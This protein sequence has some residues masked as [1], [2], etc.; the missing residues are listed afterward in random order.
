MQERATI[1]CAY[2]WQ[3]KAMERVLRR[4]ARQGSAWIREEEILNTVKGPPDARV[5][6]ATELRGTVMRSLCGALSSSPS[7]RKK[8]LRV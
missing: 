4:V 6:L 1:I 8:R 3:G 2:G 5:E 7:V